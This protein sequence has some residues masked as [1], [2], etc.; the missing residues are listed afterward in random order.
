MAAA[1]HPHTLQ[2][3]NRVADSLH[4]DYYLIGHA[5]HP[6]PGFPVVSRPSADFVHRG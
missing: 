6:A 5:Y 1:A 2:A 3:R 4:R